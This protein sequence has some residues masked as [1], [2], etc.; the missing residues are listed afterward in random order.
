MQ[1]SLETMSLEK[2]IK[3]QIKRYTQRE[4]EKEREI[5]REGR[6]TMVQVICY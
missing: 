5:D 4:K 3:R 6:K 1:D 2:E